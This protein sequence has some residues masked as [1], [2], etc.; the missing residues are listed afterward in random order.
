MT[1]ILPASHRAG[2]RALAPERRDWESAAG[3]ITTTIVDNRSMQFAIT[4]N[5]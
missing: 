3:R 4:F 5:F 1:G 2:N